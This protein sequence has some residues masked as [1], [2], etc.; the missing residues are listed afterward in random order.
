E[1]FGVW[2]NLTRNEIARGGYNVTTEEARMNIHVFQSTTSPTSSTTLTNDVDPTSSTDLSSSTIPSSSTNGTA[3]FWIAT[4]ILGLAA[5]VFLY[6]R[7]H[8]E[9][10]AK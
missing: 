8:K 3:G 9:R 1:A 10:K 7:K 4:V 5:A 2:L 6:F